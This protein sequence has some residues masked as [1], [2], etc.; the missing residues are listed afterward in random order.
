MKKTKRYEFK[1]QR[2]FFDVLNE[3]PEDK[4]KLEFL[5]AIINK[6]FLDE[7]PKDLSFIAKISYEGQRHFIE[8]SVKGYKDRMQTDLQG[9]SLHPQGG[10]KKKPIH[11]PQ[12]EQ[13]QEQE[14]EQE[15]EQSNISV[16]PDFNDFWELYDLKKGSKEKLKKKWDNLN[17]ETKEEIMVYIPKY[18]N[19]QPDKQFRKHPGTFLNNESWKDEI[20]IKTEK[21]EKQHQQQQIAKQLYQNGLL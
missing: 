13:E 10:C 21:N 19:S 18:I 9:N 6:Q 3:I 14:K 7:N 2:S 17:Q 15:Q 5:L 12:Q 4:D 16:Y 8:K 1:F 20:I 11:P